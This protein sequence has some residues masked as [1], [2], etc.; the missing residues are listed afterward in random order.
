MVRVKV[1]IERTNKT[2]VVNAKSS[3]AK[4]LLDQLHLNEEEV[5]VVRNNTVILV[6]DIIRDN[7]T[8]KILSV[9]SGG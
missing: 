6:D 3:T 4:G 9:I 8:I 5:I 7:D 2:L 1:F